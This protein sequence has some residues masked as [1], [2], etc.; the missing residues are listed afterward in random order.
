MTIT[1]CQGCRIKPRARKGGLYCHEC[2]P[3][4]P[5]PTPPCRRCGSTSDYYASGLCRACHHTAPQ[6]VG[7]CR[8]C[9]AWGVTRVHG[10]LCRGCY[11]WNRRALPVAACRSCARVVMVNATRY[12]ACAAV[13]RSWFTPPTPVSTAWRRTGTASN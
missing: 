12:A 5:S 4:G 3:S 2:D 11:A 10:W 7:S 6:H 1:M 8:D 9:L 13:R